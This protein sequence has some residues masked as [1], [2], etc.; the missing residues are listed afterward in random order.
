MPTPASTAELAAIL[1]SA[2]RESFEFIAIP[3]ARIS[4]RSIKTADASLRSLYFLTEY[5]SRE[6][7][8]LSSRFFKPN[9]S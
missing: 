1:T 5:R 4:D 8:G 9:A 2:R 3:P 6:P 7:S